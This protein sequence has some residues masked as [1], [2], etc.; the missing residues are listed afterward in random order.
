MIIGRNTIKDTIEME[1]RIDE[2][3]F[4]SYQ[5]EKNT[6]FDGTKQIDFMNEWIQF[7]GDIWV[8]E[9]RLFDNGNFLLITKKWLWQ[10]GLMHILLM[11]LF[12]T[13]LIQLIWGVMVKKRLT[14]DDNSD[15]DMKTEQ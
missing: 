6:P 8:T 1:L 2:I 13:N 15:L 3:I 11:E 5:D 12:G 14:D 7:S 10:D 9:I 4:T